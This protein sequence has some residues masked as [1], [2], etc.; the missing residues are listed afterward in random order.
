M[1]RWNGKFNFSI[2]I[3]ATLIVPVLI[4]SH[5]CFILEESSSTQTVHIGLNVVRQ[6]IG[7]INNILLQFLKT[8]IVILLVFIII[9]LGRIDLELLNP[10]C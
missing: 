6:T 5:T 7:T 2:R 10:T 9:G 8:I 1:E 3:I 4:T